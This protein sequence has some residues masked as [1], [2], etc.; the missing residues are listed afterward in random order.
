M[1][2]KYP[3]QLHPLSAI[4]LKEALEEKKIRCDAKLLVCTPSLNTL[5]IPWNAVMR[6]EI[7]LS[8]YVTRKRRP[9]KAIGIKGYVEPLSGLMLVQAW[10]RTFPRSV[11]SWR[12]VLPRKQGSVN[13]APVVEELYIPADS[14]PLRD[15]AKQVLS[16]SRSWRAEMEKARIAPTVP[17]LIPMSVDIALA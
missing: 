6:I 1:K 2:S 13:L 11:T 9:T 17:A 4:T 7:D 15:L 8:P 14:R 12:Y 10:Q 3:P 16:E 5:V